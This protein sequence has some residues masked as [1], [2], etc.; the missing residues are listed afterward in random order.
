MRYQDFLTKVVEESTKAASRDYAA[1]TK[2]AH[3]EGSIAGLKACLDKSPPQ[4]AL[5]LERAERVHKKTIATKTNIGRYWRVR[6]FFAEVEWVCNVMSVILMTQ[7]MP[8]IVPPTQR[9]AKFA[10]ELAR[11][12]QPVN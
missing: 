5:L 3:R 8:T 4:L 6:C 9:A 10:S 11:E 7:G 1:R 12:A 2:K